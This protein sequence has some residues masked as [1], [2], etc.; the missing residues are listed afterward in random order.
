[1]ITGQIHSDTHSNTSN[2]VLNVDSTRDKVIF[3]VERYGRGVLVAWLLITLL[4]LPIGIVTTGFGQYMIEKDYASYNANK[5][6]IEQQSIT[7]RTCNITMPIYVNCSTLFDLI[8]DKNINNSAINLIIIE[9]C[10]LPNI[11]KMLKCVTTGIT[12][13]NNLGTHI[14]YRTVDQY[15]DWSHANTVRTAGISILVVLGV[16]LCMML[17]SIYLYRCYNRETKI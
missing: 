10:Y 6:L 9:A 4:C 8:Y 1:M 17:T 5:P 7:N 13:F 3:Y 2:D 12:L 15:N 14:D 16:S 11:T